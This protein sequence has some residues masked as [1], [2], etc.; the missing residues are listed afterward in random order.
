MVAVSSLEKFALG[1]AAGALVVLV[2]GAVKVA[3]LAVIVAGVSYGI[4]Y[5][6]AEKKV[7]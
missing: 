1:V 5:L 6:K 4:R 3:V 2:V 7:A